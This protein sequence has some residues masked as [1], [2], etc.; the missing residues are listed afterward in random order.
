VGHA[1]PEDGV[2]N[3]ALGLGKT[4]VDGGISWTYSPAYPRITPPFGN[5]KEW[6]RNTQIDFWAV[7]MGKP[8]SF[9]PVKETEYLV[10]ENI[11]TAEK[12]DALTHIA[13][14][15]NAQ[16]DRITMGIGTKGP[17]IITFAP[18][19]AQ[20][21]FPV[22]DLV[23]HLLSVCAKA[24]KAPVEIEFAMT[25]DPVRFGFLQIRPMVV[26][27]EEISIDDA[28]LTADN[29]LVASEKVLGN[30]SVEDITDIVY[31]KPESFS[32][33]HTPKIALELERMNE[34]LLVEGT[35]YL[36]IG[37]GRWGSSDPWLGIPVD[38]GQ[39]SGAKTVIEATLPDMNVELSQGSHFF[40]NITSLQICYFSVLHSSKYTIDWDWLA[41]Q[42][43]IDEF[44]FVKHVKSH[45]DLK[46]K[47]DGRCGRG[48]IY[49]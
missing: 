40:H 25:F 26:S 1:K 7:N 23:Q 47:V 27:S 46:I 8:P 12:D 20:L 43:R 41:H 17:R 10:K 9:D 45:S 5:I 36:L 38:W 19:L 34:K 31:V 3:L 42:E 14:T 29:V 15:Y 6:F 37:F 21:S 48:V 35:P 22:N 16:S 32:A 44:D 18:L 24:V 11:T 33:E 49:R 2:A 28:E 13:S 39:V 4:I 30:G